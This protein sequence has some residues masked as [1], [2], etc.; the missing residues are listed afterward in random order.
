MKSFLALYLLVSCSLLASTEPPSSAPKAAVS[1]TDDTFTHLL[2]APLLFVKR[3][4]YTDIHI[5]DTFYE[6]H[7]DG[8][9]IYLLENPNAPRSKW[10][11]RPVVAPESSDS[12]GIGVY[13]DPELSYDGTRLLFCFKGSSDGNT[14]IYE[15]DLDGKNLRRL[16]D[17]GPT[18]V[19]YNGTRTGQHDVA[20]AYLPDGRIVFLST[21]QSGLVP[22]NNTGVA[23]LHVANADGSDIHP[24]S[25]NFV[26]EFDPTVLPD[27]RILFG[28]WE[29][30][31]KNALTIQSLW[32][33]NPDGTQ[34]TALYANNMVFPEAILDARPVPNSHLLVGTL[35]KHNERSRGAI[36]FLNPRM[37]KNNPEALF[38]LEHPEKPTFDLGQSSDPWALNKDTVLFSGR[39]KGSK[40]NG[41]MLMNRTGHR[42]LLLTNPTISLHSP[43][44]VKP[45]DT[46]PILPS[47]TDRSASTGRFLVQNVYEG[48]D[49]VKQ[50][51]VKWLRVVEETSR[52]STSNM[53]GSPYNQT[54]LVSAALAFSAKNYLGVVPVHEDG[55][56]YFE[57]PAGR[58][59][60]L[61][62]L[63]KDHRLVQSMRTF[64]QAA[65]G[66][67]RSCV[68]CHED[69]S[70]APPPFP[71]LQQV[72][73][74][75]PNRLQPES[76]GSGHMDYPTMIQPIF[77]Q[78]CVPCHGGTSGIAAGLDLTGGW[79]EHFSIS[80]ENL[81][82]RR[83]HQLEASLIAGIDCM[84][85]TAHWSSQIFPPRSHGS[86]VAPLA[87]KLMENHGGTDLTSTERDL[88]MAWIDSNGLY[89][90]TWDSTLNGCATH[91]W[92]E[93]Q[94]ALVEEMQK[95]GCLGC[96]ESKEGDHS[97]LE[98]DWINLQQ[99]HLSR[100]LRAPL[101]ASPGGTGLESCRD[102]A[103][104]PKQ[105]RIRQLVDGY[106]HVVKPIDAF[107]LRKRT[108]ADRSGSPVI[109]FE[110]SRDAP[111]QRLLA[112][113]LQARILALKQP[114]VDM[115]GAD[116][117]PG[118]S[119][120]LIAGTSPDRPPSLEAQTTPN[121]VR[122]SWDR[123]ANFSNI[124]FTLHRGSAPDFTPT[125]TTQIASLTRSSF[126][127]PHPPRGDLSYALSWPDPIQPHTPV[128]TSLSAAE[129]IRAGYSHSDNRH[130]QVLE[131]PSQK[132]PPKDVI[133]KDTAH[134]TQLLDSRVPAYRIEA[135][136]GLANLRI[137]ATE[138]L[139]LPLLND[140]DPSVCRAAIQALGRIGTARTIPRF[141][142]LL[143]NPSWEIRR[144]VQLALQRMTAMN[145]TLNDK[146]NT[147]WKQWWNESTPWRK[148]QAL[149]DAAFASPS[150][151]TPLGKKTAHAHPMRHKALRALTHLATPPSETAL[152]ALLRQQQ[153]P[154]LD[155]EEKNFLCE[156]LNRV[157]SR[158]SIPVLAKHR[159][160]AAAWA[161][162][163]L[164]GA[165][166]EKALWGFPKNLSTLL[167]LDRLN[168]TNTAP[169]IPS[170]IKQMG[171]ITYRL[172]PDDVMNRDLQ[173]IQ[174]VGA[175]LI[176]NSGLAP[177]F[178]E[179][180]LQELEDSMKP[181]INHDPRPIMPS[182]WNIMFQQMRSELKPGFVRGDG[183]TTSQPVAAMCYTAEDPK[184]TERLIP[185]LRHPAYVVRVYIALT[186]GRLNAQDAVPEITAIIRE[187][188]DFSDSV[189]QASGKHFEK[190]QTVR[191]RGFLCMALGRIGNNEA[192]LTLENIVTDSTQ[193]RDVRYGAV[194]GLDLVNS[195][196][197]LPALQCVASEDII[198]MI[199]D[200]A[201]Q[202][203]NRIQLTIE[204][205]RK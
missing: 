72:L 46:P 51:E 200:E 65:P 156:A 14:S 166:S 132:H 125:E 49:G 26:N 68:G 202:A 61:Q 171:L 128:R 186:L 85:G 153:L 108:P 15:I 47:T 187:G 89:H 76:W 42:Q 129:L 35:A 137:W 142:D 104:M 126:L 56:A 167:A 113:I 139:V 147:A 71:L 87:Q 141:I 136:Q 96:H 45:R 180:V 22:C 6:W 118:R 55:S 48:L 196:R 172:Q 114:R 162:G 28:R 40:H 99:P 169:I 58:A 146:E 25:V 127:D 145:F 111:Y 124:A 13:S 37:G 140:P 133:S 197:S 116:I 21:R 112:I 70:S 98:E 90:G 152:L 12:P 82:S 120:R 39:P 158:Q 86:G 134:F 102:R 103:I 181:P 150:P 188:Y 138:R 178:I 203:V 135:I 41:I 91:G 105:Q 33:C 67:T 189:A 19:S 192:R 59:L 204:H 44:L 77:D 130:A 117:I 119:R 74:R 62:A 57:V 17:P 179:C 66:T 50:G 20:P 190:S 149:L 1:L 64:I 175:N 159:N 95:T 131:T 27:G 122:L 191:W 194:V 195:A 24:I 184:L 185:L 8:G 11:M 151:S 205:T 161:L 69:R 78:H 63:D 160:D 155:R 168:S 157:G 53:N 106:A 2:D 23:I 174:R 80:Y 109:S 93:T 163:R 177:K 43:M 199:R 60:Y 110:S 183:T 165:E 29:Y 173:P 34:E 107:P 31:D 100:L 84:N 54:F 92:Q 88:I 16:T 7:P 5:Y 18:C 182:D 9:G 143:E 81:V 36:A 3:H 94:N 193:P 75:P 73:A 79:T 176:Q 4:S 30:V 52:V 83:D 101:R 154:P 201:R 115:P 148:E 170:L 164:G 144:N 10:H 121:G 32:T 38:N 123:H 97:F 198:W